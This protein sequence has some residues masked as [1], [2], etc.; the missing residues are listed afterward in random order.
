VD[1]PLTGIAEVF[2]VSEDGAEV[3]AG[4]LL[5]YMC[6]APDAATGLQRAFAL[7]GRAVTA[8]DAFRV[9][10]LGAPGG[11]AVLP[12]SAGTDPASL[13]R[14]RA[15][16]TAAVGSADGAASMRQIASV[17]DGDAMLRACQIYTLRLTL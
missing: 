15:V 4:D 13:E 17:P 2:A 1:V 14:L 8:A 5:L 3:A 11:A 9:L 7:R 16:Y 12:Y 10:H 6:A